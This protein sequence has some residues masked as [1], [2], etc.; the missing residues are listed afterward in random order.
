MCQNRQAL[1][2]CQLSHR[3]TVPTMEGYYHVTMLSVP[4]VLPCHRFDSV[5]IPQYFC[6]I[7][8]QG[9]PPNSPKEH[10]SKEHRSDKETVPTLIPR[11]RE[12]ILTIPSCESGIMPVRNYSERDIILTMISF[13]Q[14]VARVWKQGGL[15]KNHSKDM[16][17]PVCQ[18]FQSD[19]RSNVPTVSKYGG[20]NTHVNHPRCHRRGF[21]PMEYSI[22]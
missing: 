14:D 9:R 17:P 5:I 19:N 4:T 6:S 12:I 11:Y 21:S 18:Q 16:I 13:W 20:L 22:L 15:N 2:F 1:I 8:S 10:R 3:S 7:P